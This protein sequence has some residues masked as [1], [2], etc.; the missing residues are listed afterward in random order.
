MSFLQDTLSVFKKRDLVLL[1]S[2]KESDGVYTFLFEKEKDVTWQAGQHGLFSITHK[3]IRNSI[4]PFSVASAPSENTIKITTSIS[5]NPSDFKRAMLELEE[6]MKI[7]MSGPVGSFYLRDNCPTFLI[8]G[9]IGITPFRS[10]IKQI[11]AN[12]VTADQSIHLLYLDSSQSYLFKD[13][14]DT[15]ASSTSIHVTYLASRD[16]LY[17]KIDE[18]TNSYSNDGRFFISGPKSMVDSMHSYLQDNNI[19]KRNIKKSAFFGY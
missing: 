8:A 6:G 18:I 19:S 14:I 12:G 7:R 13:E 3:K 9:G 2:Y 17:Q 4:R 15:I 10:I 11:E 16:E 5:D 1:D